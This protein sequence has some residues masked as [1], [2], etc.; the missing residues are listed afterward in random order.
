MGDTQAKLEEYAKTRDN[1]LRNEIAIENQD[2]VWSTIQQF[3][4]ATATIDDMF[5]AG[6]VGML[7][8]IEKFDPTR[9]FKLSTYAVPW[10]KKEVRLL[11]DNP[12]YIDDIEGFTPEDTYEYNS[13]RVSIATVLAT[14]LRPQER[15]V[16]EMMHTY[17]HSINVVAILLKITSADVKQYYKSAVEKIN[18]PCIQW[19]LKVIKEYS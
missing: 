2:L 6:M 11:I 12:H 13:T 5:Q 19:Y 14:V 4:S 18:L 10:I 9:G 15:A 17:D 16:L 1:N 7:T 3:T 8:A